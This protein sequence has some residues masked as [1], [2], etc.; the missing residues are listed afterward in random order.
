L[1]A[2]LANSVTR[3]KFNLPRLS[4]LTIRNFSLYSRQPI[5]EIDFRR[6]AF[7]LAGANG[8]GK[9]T[10]LSILDFALTGA[11]PIPNRPFKSVDEYHKLVVE[12]SSTYF[13]GRISE[14][15]HESAEVS[16]KLSS[17]GRMY[18]ITR[19]MFE[20]DELRYLRITRDGQPIL[21][22]DRL[23]SAERHGRFAAEVT[24][25]IGLESFS[26]YVFL[27]HFVF[28][29][30]EGRHLLFWDQTVLEQVLY[31]A[32]G[33]DMKAAQTA[34]AL[35]RDAEKADSRAR[36]FNWQATQARR[37]L[38]DLEEAV[39]LETDTLDRMEAINAL[40][41]KLT[42][43][44][45]STE[46][47]VHKLQT[48]LS[49]VELAIA[50]ASAKQVTTRSEYED[51]YRRHLRS[52]VD[53]KKHP[54]VGELLDGLPCVI[55]GT[56][57]DAA[58][59][60]VTQKLKEGH[61]PLCDTPLARTDKR[62]LERLAALDK[63]LTEARRVLEE[64]VK[65]RER[66]AADWK[67][68]EAELLGATEQLLRFEKDNSPYLKKLLSTQGS[69]VDVAITRYREQVEELLK[70]K[71]QEYS[72]RDQTRR[73]LKLLQRKLV[74]QY[75][76]AEEVFAPN[77]RQLAELFLGISLDIRVETKETPSINL[78]IE[79]KN[80]VRRE[81]HQLSESQR[82][83]VDIALRMA[84]LQ[85]VA[86]E[87]SGALLVDTPEGSLDIAYEDRAGAMF[88]TFVEHNFNLII[89]ANINTSRLLLTLAEKCGE[90]RM[91]VCRMTSWTDLSEVQIADEDLFEE[92]FAGIENA[93]RAKGGTHLGGK[94]RG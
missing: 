32:F 5:I 13:E 85:F 83:F 21:D 90:E 40:H 8:L 44:K 16:A 87:Q 23:S 80:T 63:Q 62:V 81:I 10:F 68:A 47:K 57:S 22:G 94:L 75:A 37:K 39:D 89:T 55:C 28:T 73:D 65:K 24:K 46:S 33:V 20:P 6:G 49:D 58:I 26:Q 45:N 11:V 27:Q 43:G 54:A 36:N 91:T 92:A 19:G 29:F 52:R 15:D 70:R 3:P 78:V 51:E 74:A 4:S 30:D 77:F 60:T 41:K 64:N 72:R 93:L 17:N 56:Q 67:K 34:D 69:G 1:E 59:A 18:E 84:L 25:D 66:L 86:S 12:F 7:C 9:S 61:C 50:N 82:F 48:L 79:V 2:A 14:E 42:E 38:S 71:N 76:D 88:A 53:V 35:R 31:L